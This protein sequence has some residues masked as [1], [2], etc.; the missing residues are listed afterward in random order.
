MTLHI[1]VWI[2]ANTHNSN[3]KPSFSNLICV[4]MCICISVCALSA[5]KNAKCKL[6]EQAAKDIR[7]NRLP[8]SFQ[9]IFAHTLI[10]IVYL[11]TCSYHK[12]SICEINNWVGNFAIVKSA[13]MRNS[14]ENFSPKLA[15]IFQ[16]N[17]WC[18]FFK[19]QVGF[20]LLAFLCQS[21]SLCFLLLVSKILHWGELN[22]F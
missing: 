18:T 7:D 13:K 1:F 4:Y 15:D 17:S 9:P 12:K 11:N 10:H 16:R 3:S 21:H 6:P 8:H 14:K 19:Y 22:L 5:G 20:W 2:F